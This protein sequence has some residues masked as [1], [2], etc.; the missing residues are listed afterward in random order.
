M[1]RLMFLSLVMSIICM[2]NPANASTG[3][4]LELGRAT[5]SYNQ[6]KIDGQD[7][8]RFNLAPV[9]DSVQYHRLSFVTKLN[10]R[11]G[12]RFLYAP[13]KFSGQKR[14]SKDINF[15]GV[16]FL[17]GENTKTEYQ[18]NSYRGTYFYELLTSE[19][20]FLRLGGTLKVR[21]ALVEL[22]QNNRKKFKK[23]TGIVP[24]VYLYSEYK[25]SNDFLVAFDFDGL[26][27]PQGRAFDVALLAGYKFSPAFQVNLGLRM[28]E[29]GA[30]NKNVYN[31]SQ[32]NYY[33]TSVQ[34]NF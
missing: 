14:F 11:H 34:V 13:L 12:V 7:G 26:M 23:N 25:W 4:N 21:D 3:L 27:A 15:N 9:L 28:L 22:K 1:I 29:G 16:T 8:T 10:S 32:V 20:Y 5:N 24:L 2:A 31:F 18:F 30:D 19:N 6:V 33:F 17:A